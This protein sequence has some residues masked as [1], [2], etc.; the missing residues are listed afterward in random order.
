MFAFGIVLPEVH[1]I[2]DVA[3]CTGSD[4]NAVL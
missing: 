1:P 4:H 2:K 3:T